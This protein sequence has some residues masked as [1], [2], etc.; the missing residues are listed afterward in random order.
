LKI[1][2]FFQ[3]RLLSIRRDNLISHKNIVA[4]SH[5]RPDRTNKKAAAA[6]DKFNLT[7]VLGASYWVKGH[8]G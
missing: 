4:V 5:S 7:V 6:L 8:L 3:L 1:Y 2:A